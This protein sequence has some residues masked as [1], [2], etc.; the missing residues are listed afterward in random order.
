MD[1]IK[2]IIYLSFPILVFLF[3]NKLEED[4][5]YSFLFKV[6]L[7]ISVIIYIFLVR[8]Y[9]L[10]I[11]INI[12]LLLAYLNRY[13]KIYL[14]INVLIIVYFVFLLKLPISIILPQYI[15]LFLF[16][17]TTN[18][19][20]NMFIAVTSYFYSFI[21]FMYDDVSF[22]SLGTLNVLLVVLAYY[23]FCIILKYMTIT[24]KNKYHKLEERYRNYLFRFIH[25]VKNPIAVCKGYLEMFNKN[26]DVNKKEK[27]IEL[28]SKQIDESLN[29]MED[30]LVYGRFNVVLD[31]M[32]LCLL[33]EDVYSDFSYLNKED[34]NIKL[35]CDADELII[36]GDYNKLRQVL[37]N[38]IKNSLEAKR[39]NEPL[40][41]NI[42][43]SVNNNNN[44]VVKITDNG[45]GIDNI[46][47][48]GN[49]FY[50]TKSSGNG[51]GVNFCK[52]I[53][54]MHKGKI[55]YSSKKGM[56]TNVSI[57]LPLTEM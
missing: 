42:S 11:L 12:P 9:R 37:V 31:Y 50:S 41:I 28:I 46:E 6:S 49:K 45:V 54:S 7:V 16:L 33:I 52:T 23:F 3:F 40:N 38:I 27:Y 1:F 5:N 57:M 39:E 18:S 19:K 30:Y 22:L 13:K 17:M 53:I 24:S 4:R 44:I 2:A 51:L 15:L 48:L 55:R 8:D 20:L 34:V 43:V 56:G 32:D 21:Y 10:S 26:S 36:M 29:I 35:K 14:F 47:R 25:E